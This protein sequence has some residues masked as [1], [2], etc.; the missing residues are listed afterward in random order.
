ME[1]VGKID[2]C[3]RRSGMQTQLILDGHKCL[4]KSTNPC[5]GNGSNFTQNS[6]TDCLR[7]RFAPIAAT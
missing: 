5:R 1:S 4:Q 6:R 2:K 3:H 7:A